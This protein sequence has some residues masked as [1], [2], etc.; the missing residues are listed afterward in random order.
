M[1]L[2][3]LDAALAAL[4]RDG[5]TISYG[6]LARQLVVPGPGSIA[7]LTAALEAMMVEDAALGRPLRAALCHAR[8]SDLPA[9]GFFEAAQ[10]LGCFNG[11]DAA[12][13]VAAERAAL[14]KMAG[15]R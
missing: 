2:P 13:F 5:E 3:G 15:L 10:A 11:A 6:A 7:K 9:K 14:F 8:G 4:A 12:A 1:S